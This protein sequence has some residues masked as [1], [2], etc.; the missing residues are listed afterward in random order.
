MNRIFGSRNGSG[1]I[2]G[3]GEGEHG[4]R[5]YANVVGANPVFALRSEKTFHQVHA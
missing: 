2:R 1:S 4:V 5:P 3:S